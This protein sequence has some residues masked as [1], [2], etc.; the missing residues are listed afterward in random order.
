[1]K[2]PSYD[3]LTPSI[4][5]VHPRDTF[6]YAARVIPRSDEPV[7]SAYAMP[8]TRYAPQRTDDSADAPG[9]RGASQ[10]D[11]QAGREVPALFAC[12]RTHGAA[13]PGVLS[14]LA[15]EFSPRIER[16]GDTAAVL[17]ISGLE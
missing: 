1:M 13:R 9:D 7:V 15:R 5:D 12:L 4:S 16:D 10:I 8:A 17:D 3:D 11:C 14:A 2:I 6:D